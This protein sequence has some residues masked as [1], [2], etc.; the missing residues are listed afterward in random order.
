MRTNFLTNAVIATS[1]ALLLLVA[2]ISIALAKDLQSQTKLGAANVS[3]RPVSE[4]GI[5]AIGGKEDSSR[6][7]TSDTV[8]YKYKYVRDRGKYKVEP[9]E[10]VGPNPQPLPPKDTKGP[11]KK[12]LGEAVGLNPQPLPPGDMGGMVK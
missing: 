2:G 9:G 3:N 12:D 5:D 7:S 8:L 4:R 6:A 1:M 11:V 10:E